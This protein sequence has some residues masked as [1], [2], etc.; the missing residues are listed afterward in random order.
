MISRG[1]AG[2]GLARLQVII[3]GF[4]PEDLDQLESL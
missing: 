4:K 1:E 2:H 3:T